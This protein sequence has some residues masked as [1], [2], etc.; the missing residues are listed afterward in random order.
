MNPRGTKIISTIGYALSAIFFFLYGPLLW[1]TCQSSCDSPN[2]T[3][4]DKMGVGMLWAMISFS[5]IWLL[6]FS[7]ILDLIAF[8]RTKAFPGQL[9]HRIA[10]LNGSSLLGILV[11]VI[12]FSLFT[13]N[14]IPISDDCVAFTIQGIILSLFIFIPPI[15][16]KWQNS[17]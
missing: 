17:R 12:F 15:L 13:S 7:L 3:C 2:G 1:L 14:T 16:N 4:V 6:T 11:C 8:H 5:G 10:W 9:T